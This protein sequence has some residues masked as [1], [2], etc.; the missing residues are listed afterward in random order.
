MPAATAGPGVHV[1]RQR[2]A[3]LT[4]VEGLWGVSHRKA[5]R[6]TQRKL[7]ARPAPDLVQRNFTTDAPDRW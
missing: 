5:L 3:R 2:V 4:G 7:G 1:G 6:T